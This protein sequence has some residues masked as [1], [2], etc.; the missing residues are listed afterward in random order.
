M[1]HP[2]AYGGNQKQQFSW[3]ACKILISHED[4]I[5]SAARLEDP[6]HTTLVSLSKERRKLIQLRFCM[7]RVQDSGDPHSIEH[8]LVHDSQQFRTRGPS[9]EMWNR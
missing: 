3:P 7:G 6:Q 9:D 2:K 5:G 1:I 4:A 8:D